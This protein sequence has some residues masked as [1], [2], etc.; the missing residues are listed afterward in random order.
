MAQVA[1]S[2]PL[3]AWRESRG[4]TLAWCAAKVGVTRQAWS[5]WE[6]GRR[7]PNK[8]YMPKIKDI[9]GGAIGADDFYPQLDEAA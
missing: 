9:T 2:H 4:K 1:P 3:R 6:R 5:D 7:I 8:T